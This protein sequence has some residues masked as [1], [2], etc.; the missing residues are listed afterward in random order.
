MERFLSRRPAALAPALT[1]L[2]RTAMKHFPRI[3]GRNLAAVAFAV[4]AAAALYLVARPTCYAAD[5]DAPAPKGVAAPFDF[6]PPDAEWFMTVRVGDLWA[7][8]VA[9]TWRMGGE[10]WRNAWRKAGKELPDDSQRLLSDLERFLDS[11][12]EMHIAPD[13]VERI[14]LF[15]LKEPPYALT[16]MTM[17]K[18]YDR[19]AILAAI[20][21]IASRSIS[22]TK[23]DG[24]S[25]S[26]ISKISLSVHFFDERTF[27]VGSKEA[28]DDYLHGKAGNKE[29]PAVP[30]LRLAAEKHLV[31]V[32]M[33][34][35]AYA[36][37]LPPGNTPYAPLLKAQLAAL[38]VDLDDQFKANLRL[39]FA[40][41]ADAKAAAVGLDAALGMFRNQF[42]LRAATFSKYVVQSPKMTALLDD[43][44]TALK[45]AKADQKGATVTVEAA[46]KIDPD[47]TTAALTEGAS[48]IEKAAK[49]NQVPNDLKQ[50][51]LALAVFVYSSDNDRMPAAAIY[52]KNGKPLLSWRVLLLP[53]IEQGKLYS[54][55]HLDEPWDSDH[56]MKLLAK[57]PAT[58]APPDSKAFKEHQTHFQ[59]LVGKG[60][61]FESPAAPQPGLAANG[62][63]W[64]TDIPDGTS[65]TILF[66]EAKKAVPW[67]KP[68]DIPFD[69]GKLLP[70]V[71]GLSKGGFW[72]AMCDGSVRF[73]PLTVKEEV[74]RAW[75]IRNSGE[76]K[77]DFN[78]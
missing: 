45:A 54:E 27:L 75:I 6:V 60:T 24:R 25:P 40:N 63:R 1:F 4:V 8:P 3:G 56:N 41:E 78:K 72:A 70:K 29:G 12:R 58:F 69:D 7:H 33:D 47:T 44:Q 46:M 13:E 71:G 9:K 21:K 49:R 5:K 67:T 32:G 31:V 76:V 68:D 17:L 65:N 30:A 48:M 36:R 26:V 61:V 35:A 14:T 77:P 50:L 62:L 39:T 20:E 73:I 42:A 66:V 10:A 11:G 22:V 34:A 51:A 28:M 53:C 2:E 16:A 23:T 74:L 18:P 59:A 15:S 64:P 52:D 43:V 19:K 38:V 37:K 57:M 55:F